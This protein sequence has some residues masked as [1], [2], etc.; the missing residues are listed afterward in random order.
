MTGA[1]GVSYPQHPSHPI[2]HFEHG[3]MRN[4]AA[5]TTGWRAE[6]RHAQLAGAVNTGTHNWLARLTQA[7]TTGWRAE[8]SRAKCRTLRD[9]SDGSASS[10]TP[11]TPDPAFRTRLDAQHGWMRNRAVH[12]RCGNL[13]AQQRH[14]LDNPV[15]TPNRGPIDWQASRMRRRLHVDAF[16]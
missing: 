3:W 14:A 12:N 1:T 16:A 11:V 2:L 6:H 10:A 7:R 13:H 5:R 9:R 15:C 4:R 8:Q